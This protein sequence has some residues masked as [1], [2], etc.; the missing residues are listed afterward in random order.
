[1]IRT[2]PFLIAALDKSPLNEIIYN[3]SHTGRA[4]ETDNKEV[5]RIL[6]ELTL[7]TDAAEWI[8][9]HRLRHD[10]RSDWIVLCENYDDPT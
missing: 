7:G 1:M 10:G 9:T 6:D 5:H 4:F 3:A 2:E 8:K